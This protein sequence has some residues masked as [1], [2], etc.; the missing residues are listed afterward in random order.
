MN[1]KFLIAGIAGF[2]ISLFGGFLFHGFILQ[3]DYAQIPTLMRTEAD[4]ASH[5]PFMLAS[6]FIKGFAFAWIYSKGI[7]QGSPAITQGLKFGIATV[8]LVTIPL[9][10]VYYA[11]KP[12]PGMLVAK[13]IVFDSI[14]MVLMG[15][16]VS[17]IIKP[18]AQ[19]S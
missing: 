3:G 12:M 8:F 13:Q 16:V 14:V 4:Q 17:L 1:V 2:L 5:L 18:T 9:Y 19:S 15:I 10:L 11:V 7:T 6:H